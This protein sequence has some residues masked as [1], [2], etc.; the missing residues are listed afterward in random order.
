[1]L[2]DVP[3]QRL[4]RSRS[5][6]GA[7]VHAR[8]CGGAQAKAEASMRASAPKVRERTRGAD[9]ARMGRP[10]PAVVP[11]HSTRVVAKSGEIPAQSRYGER[12]SRARVRS[13]ATRCMLEPSRER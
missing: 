5:A 1:M 7:V 12:P 6:G 13:P 10:P 2:P 11:C 3:Y 4:I 9:N 8:R